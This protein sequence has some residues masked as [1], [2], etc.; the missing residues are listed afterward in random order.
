MRRFFTNTGVANV[1][2]TASRAG[3]RNCET[4][5]ISKPIVYDSVKFVGKIGVEFLILGNDP[6]G[7]FAIS[8]GFDTQTVAIDHENLE[9]DV[10]AYHLPVP[11]QCFYRQLK[12]LW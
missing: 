8:F 7:C 10:G 4:V 9:V 3:R 1:I 6:S 5:S 11:T 2:D 12:K